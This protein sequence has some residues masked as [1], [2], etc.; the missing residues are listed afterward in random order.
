MVASPTWATWSIVAVDRKSGEVGTA[1]A[2]CVELPS[3]YARESGLLRNVVLVAGV[4]AGVTQAN[5]N[6]EA[7]DRIRASLREGAS[8]DAVVREVSSPSFDDRAEERQHAVAR[9][10][11]PA[12]PAAFTGSSTLPWSGHRSSTGVSVQGN[13]LRSPRVA[14]ASLAAFEAAA[15]ADLETRLVTALLAGARA[16]GD[17]RCS[18]EQTALFAQVAVMDRS[19]A[20]VVRGARARP[21]DGRNPVEML[22]SG[23]GSED[24]TSPLIGRR[25]VVVTLSLI[26]TAVLLVLGMVWRRRSRRSS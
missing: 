22:A 16:G 15:G 11:A 1:I 26:G 13:I 2:S 3:W 12:A 19:G 25:A 14:A 8:A 21:D 24:V 7:A 17:S 10:D 6:L 5:V 20:L 18:E 9:L 23:A 4:A